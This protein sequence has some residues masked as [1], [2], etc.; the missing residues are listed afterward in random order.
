MTI[1]ADFDVL[2]DGRAVPL[3]SRTRGGARPGAGRPKKTDYSKVIS[4]AE[5]FGEEPPEPPA[6]QSNASRFDVAKTRKE[7]A[8]A[9]IHDLNFKIQSGAYLPRDA[10]REAT[11]TVL[12]AISQSLRSL[13]D[14]IERRH[15]VPPKV[16]QEIEA[17]IDQVLAEAAENLALFTEAR[18]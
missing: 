16:L 12:A 14:A 15:S 13:P 4:E 9:N 5:L 2:P 6:Q 17:T 18:N 10:Y 8:L 11:A 1:D 3:K 7:E